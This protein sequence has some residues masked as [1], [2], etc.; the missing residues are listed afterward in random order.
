MDVLK[1]VGLLVIISAVFSY[2][3]VRFVKLPGTIGVMTI[4]IVVSLIILVAGK[5]D[6]GISSTIRSL[7]QSIDFSKVLL[8]VMLGFLLFA[9]ALHFDF[10]KLK[11]Q[12][13]AIFTLSTIGVVISTVVFGFLL[14]GLTTLLG[15]DLPLIYCF[16]FGALISPTDP[17]AVGAILKNSNI[18]ARL[19]T[20]ISGESMFNDAVGLIVFVT[21]LGIADSSDAHFSWAHTAKMFGQEVIGGLLIGLVAGY[22]GYKLMRSISDFQTVLLLS[23][24]LVFSISAVANVLHASVPLGVVAAGLVVGNH[25][26]GKDNPVHGYLV[27]IWKLLDEVLNTILFVMIGLQL[28]VLPFLN[29][30]WFIGLLSIVVVLIARLAS[31]VLPA[32][33][34][35]R[36]ASAGNLVILT[37][38]GL[39]GGISI[40]MALSLPESDYRETIL[41]ACYFIVIFSVVVQGL[42]LNKVVSAAMKKKPVQEAKR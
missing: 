10:Q 29:N 32:I 31:I 24:A 14:D 12:R 2:L 6:K 34:L 38:A 33:F 27:Q 19:E 8:D 1:I 17:I 13:R 36:R 3:N 18:P 35:V 25:N 7:T 28:V 5:T 42:T 40:A 11:Q 9:A 23:V 20:I 4:S 26:F 22:I 39:R 16:I 15:I 37:W 21:L 41:A 30:Y